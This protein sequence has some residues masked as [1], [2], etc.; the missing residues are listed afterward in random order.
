MAGREKVGEL[1]KE[2]GKN[3]AAGK[4]WKVLL[5]YLPLLRL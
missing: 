2:R 3:G 5:F 4:M 1:V